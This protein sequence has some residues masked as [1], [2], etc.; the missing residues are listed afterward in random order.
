MAAKPRLGRSDWLKAG[1]T[2]LARDGAAALRAEALAREIG[3]TKGSFYWHFADVPAF[4][5]ELLAAWSAQANAALTARMA[6]AATPTLALRDIARAMAAPGSV[7]AAVRAWAISDEAAAQAVAAVDA[8]R[9][10]LIAQLLG[11]LG[12]S[13]PD[14]PLVITAAAHGLPAS[15]AGDPM[16]TLVDLVL[17]LR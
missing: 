17:A 16:G 13:N 7:D 1:F 8:E 11:R 3:T 6:G 10:A 9:V 15:A 14:L 12:V 4:H 2:A 5:A